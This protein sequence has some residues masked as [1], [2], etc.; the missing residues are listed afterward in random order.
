MLSNTDGDF[1]LI[2]NPYQSQVDLESLLSSSNSNSE[3]LNDQFIY[4][5][6]PTLG[7]RGGYATVDISLNDITNVFVGVPNDSEASKYLQPNQAFFV[8]TTDAS[9]ELTFREST[10]N[11]NDIQTSTFNFETETPSHINVN[12]KYDDGTLV[13]GVRVVF[14]NTYSENV[15]YFDA[16]KTWNFD[17]SLTLYS[18]N[19]NLSIEKRPPPTA[20]D[21]T[22]LHLY[23]YTKSSYAFEVEFV[24]ENESLQ[25]I[26]LID[27]YTDQSIAVTP[28]QIMSYEFTIDSNIPESVSPDRFLLTY[29]TSTLSVNDFEND[30]IAFYPNPLSGKELFIILNETWIGKSAQLKLFDLS[31]RLINTW[32]FDHLNSQEILNLNNLHNGLYILQL[33]SGENIE[34]FKLKKNNLGLNLT[35]HY[36]FKKSLI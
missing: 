24:T 7:N 9:P 22:Q 11:N 15:D 14:D 21:T 26:F 12:L 29:E 5:Y 13:D 19:T 25:D 6:E 28:N 8:Q 18:K 10:K 32:N 35:L 1:N 4:I 16:V 23:N 3:G 33:S 2:G 34:T 17:E 36:I 27:Q 31:S 20:T 30:K